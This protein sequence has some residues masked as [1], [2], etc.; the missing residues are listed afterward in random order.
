[1]AEGQDIN[2]LDRFVKKSPHLVLEEHGHCEVPAG[3]G[4]VVLRWRNPQAAVPVLIHLYSPWEVAW[5]LD[6]LTPRSG[7]LDLAPG[8]HVATFAMKNVDLSG[9]LLMF[10]AI[11]D[12]KTCQHAPKESPLKILTDEDGTWKCMLNDPPMD[13]WMSAT[14]DD[15]DWIALKKVP[16]PKLTWEDKGGYQGI[17]ATE[18]GAAFLG[19]GPP[20]QQK[21]PSSWWQKWFSDW[22]A[23]AQGD[24]WI[25]K[26][27]E[28][29]ASPAG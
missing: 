8:T 20:S 25:R 1:M 27:F 4:G 3:C 24:V 17:H 16:T 19:I 29:P 22:P 9:G 5:H 6:G 26:V 7:R 28:V 18:A 13:D 15:R 21:Q 14:F 2:S 10:A 12:P 11:H 23:Q